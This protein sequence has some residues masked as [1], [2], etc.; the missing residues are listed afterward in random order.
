MLLLGHHVSSE[1]GLKV[2]PTHPTASSL[3]PYPQWP[4]HW[5]WHKFRCLL[6]EWSWGAQQART[7]Q[8]CGLIYHRTAIRQGGMGHRVERNSQGQGRWGHLLQQ[9]CLLSPLLCAGG[10][11]VREWSCVPV[12]GNISLWWQRN[13]GADCKGIHSYSILKFLL[14][15]KD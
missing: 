14:V 1:T 11:L 8:L 13:R 9:W 4:C 10:G 6:T 5:H 15:S 2:P 7:N 12:R 3:F